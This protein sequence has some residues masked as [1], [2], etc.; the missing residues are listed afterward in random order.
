MLLAY[1]DNGPGPVVVLLHGFPFDRGMWEAQQI[2][3]GST[4]RLITPDLRGHGESAAPT[5]IYTMDDMADDVV[6]LLDAL[7]IT[8]PV[9]LGGLSMG[10]YVAL[11]LAVRHPKRLRGLMLLDT[12]ATADTPEAARG[13]EELAQKVEALGSAEPVVKAMVPKLFSQATRL[14]RPELIARLEE[15]MLRTPARGVA[16]ALRGMAV[17]PDRTGELSRISVP[18]LVIVGSEDV[19]TPPT[20]ARA[21]AQA[22]PNAE[23]VEIPDAGHLAPLENPAPAN[24]AMLAF[25]EALA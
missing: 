12:K 15:R 18:T 1:A 21:M 22:L 4:Y 16:G 3:L 23:L 10:G 13:R 2:A 5:G 17:R 9:V 7:R 24:A 11:A 20:E 19:I 14:N 6:E 8:E 25:L